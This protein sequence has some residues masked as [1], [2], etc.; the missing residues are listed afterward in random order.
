MKIWIVCDNNDI[1][2]IRIF[3]SLKKAEK[4]VDK[5]NDYK[6]DDCWIFDENGSEIE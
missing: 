2:S 1:P 5:Y 4:H 6:K 3:E